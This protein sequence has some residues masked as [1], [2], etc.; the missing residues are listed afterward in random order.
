MLLIERLYDVIFLSQVWRTPQSVFHVSLGL[1]VTPQAPPPVRPVHGTHT[2]AEGPAPAHL[3][4]QKHT[5]PV[6][7]YRHLNTI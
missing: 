3:A 6:S 2:L 5:T 1:S 4:T 7:A